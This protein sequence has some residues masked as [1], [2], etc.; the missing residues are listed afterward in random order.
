MVEQNRS[1]RHDLSHVEIIVHDHENVDVIRGNLRG[2]KRSKDNE[3]PSVL[4]FPGDFINPFEA[5]ANQPSFWRRTSKM[6][7]SLLKGNRENPGREVAVLV[8]RR[9]GHRSTICLCSLGSTRRSCS[10][11]NGRVHRLLFGFLIFAS[12]KEKGENR[13]EG[14][15]QLLHGDKL[16]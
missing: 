15:M 12:P 11:E 3:S 2:H 1:W 14:F 13:R 10:Q 5:C 6:G 9:D 4:C 7:E 8:K 16:F